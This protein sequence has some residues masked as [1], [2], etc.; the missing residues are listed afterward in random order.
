[1]QSF[2]EVLV[3]ATW[4]AAP[5]VAYQALMHGVQRAPRPFALIFAL[6]TAAVALT[7]A[8]VRADVAAAGFGAVSP[9]AVLIPWAG[10]AVLSVLFFMLGL[11]GA[12]KE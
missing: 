4:G 9:P 7:W 3:Y 2:T 11:K 6:Y 12:K 8:S 5:I 1:M 10:T